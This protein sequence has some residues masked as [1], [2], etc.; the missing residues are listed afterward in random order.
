MPRRIV[1]V[2]GNFPYHITAR[3]INRDWFRIPLPEVWSLMGDYLS[4]IVHEYKVVV[5]GFVLMPNHFHLNLL[6]PLGNI[7]SAMN[8]FMRE[9]SRE[10]TRLSGR[11]NQ[12]Y[13]GRNHK[14]L[15]NSHHYFLNVYKYIY[16]NP[17]RAGLC[18]RVEEYPYSSIAALVGN[19]HLPFSM[20]EDTL[21]FSPD[22]QWSNLSWLN[23][24]SR[25]EHEE[26]IRKALRRRIFTL[27][28]EKSGAPSA[29][30]KIL[31]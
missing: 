29:L 31:I 13:G 19:I 3:C 18:E 8:Y 22:F 28:K 4:L 2:T 9:T 25:R 6:A 12:T 26:Q 27:A 5:L 10:I 7:S 16:R 30:E 20:A 17:V 21:L 14:C 1:P 23:T 15:I 11:I 24:P